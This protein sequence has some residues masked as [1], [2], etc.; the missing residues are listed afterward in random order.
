VPT[1]NCDILID[2]CYILIDES[3]I[4]CYV[5]LRDSI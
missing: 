2:E 1:N 3:Y 5:K 4:E